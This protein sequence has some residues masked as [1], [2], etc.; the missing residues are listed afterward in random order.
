MALDV[1]KVWSPQTLDTILAGPGPSNRM[2]IF[3]G[4]AEIDWRVA[5][6]TLARDSVEIVLSDW[7][8]DT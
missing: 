3:T 2:F 8:G 1:K 5:S 7:H 6:D 4:I